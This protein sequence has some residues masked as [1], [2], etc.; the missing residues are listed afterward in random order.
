MSVKRARPPVFTVVDV[1][2]TTENPIYHT[3][4]KFGGETVTATGLTAK[5]AKQNAAARLLNLFGYSFT[6]EEP[7]EPH[8]SAESKTAPEVT[9][10]EGG[11][12]STS[13][14]QEVTKVYEMDTPAEVPQE[15]EGEMLLMT[16]DLEVIQELPPL[17]NDSSEVSYMEKQERAEQTDTIPTYEKILTSSR[18]GMKILRWKHQ[19][20][21]RRP[22]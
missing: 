6:V 10:N 11:D 16:K 5:K 7:E 1:D 15:T 4:V 8:S 22:I 19:K 2:R 21:H 18:T 9:E 13:E 3:Q 12:S 14:I 17:M 20:Y